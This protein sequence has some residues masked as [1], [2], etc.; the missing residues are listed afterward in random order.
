M[1]T[2]RGLSCTVDGRVV[3][4]GNIACMKE[5][6]MSCDESSLSRLAQTLQDQGKTGWFPLSLVSLPQ[7]THIRV[8]TSDACV[9]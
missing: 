2:G 5:N 4:V 7:L 3:F 8:C 9:C 1:C 6:V